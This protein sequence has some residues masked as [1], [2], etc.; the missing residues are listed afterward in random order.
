MCPYGNKASSST[1]VMMKLI[2]KINEAVITGLETEDEAIESVID[3]DT[4]AAFH[5]ASAAWP[6]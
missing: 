1:Q 6:C 4:V 3:I 2:L 5:S